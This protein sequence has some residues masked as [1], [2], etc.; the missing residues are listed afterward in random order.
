MAKAPDEDDSHK[1][2]AEEKTVVYPMANP[3]L[4]WYSRLSECQAE[5]LTRRI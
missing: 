1:I 4:E 3:L 2:W 5:G